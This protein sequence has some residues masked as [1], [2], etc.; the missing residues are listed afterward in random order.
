ML[1]SWHNKSVILSQVQR[2]ES[3][4]VEDDQGELMRTMGVVRAL[5]GVAGLCI[6]IG[7]CAANTRASA[8]NTA[9]KVTASDPTVETLFVNDIHFEPFADP[10]KAARLR[11]API[12]EWNEILAEPASTDQAARFAELQTTCK[13]RGRGHDLRVISIEFGGNQGRCR[14]REV[15]GAERRFDCAQFSM[16]VRGDFSRCEAGRIPGVC[17]EDDRI[18][19]ARAARG[20]A[21]RAG[22]CGA[23]K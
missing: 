10:A 1:E 17:G 16:Q 6:L 3:R 21:G 20:T 9:T 14:W 13:A 15:C 22:V 2:L 11:A 19:D 7:C 5:R 23:G 4:L 12:S 8:Q 18:R